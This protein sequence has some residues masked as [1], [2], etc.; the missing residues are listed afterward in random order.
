M[1]ELNERKTTI[2]VDTELLRVLASKPLRSIELRI[3][4][5]LLL[6]EDLAPYEI[7][8]MTDIK[9]ANI[10]S[11]L[12]RLFT[13]HIINVVKQ[14]KKGRFLRVS[15]NKSIKERTTDAT[16]ERNEGLCAGGLAAS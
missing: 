8:D 15:L 11:S 9:Q 3:I 16:E 5:C 6:K 14:S 4:L 12:H 1:E 13:K 2:E 7:E 10:S